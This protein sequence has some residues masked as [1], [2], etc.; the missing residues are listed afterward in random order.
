MKKNLFIF[1]TTLLLISCSRKLI[2]NFNGEGSLVS[3]INKE[4]KSGNASHKTPIYLD[5]L[6]I[7]MEDLTFLNIVDTKD[8]TSIKVL[9]KLAAK[10]NI[11]SNIN[12]KV[13]QLIPFKDESLGLKHYANINNE[14]ITNTIN[15]LLK[16][17]Q[18]NANPILVL[19][20]IP[21][22]GN[23]ISS[24]INQVKKSEIKSISILKKQAAYTIYGIRAINGVIIITT[25][26]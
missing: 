14:L 17:G 13:I 11:N 12:Q 16:S 5:T 1:F 3:I 22:R 26:K 23:E 7:S 25:K 24:K 18:V 6:K 9:N 15:S 20:G 8:F 19:D 4:I 21:L 2:P 10:K